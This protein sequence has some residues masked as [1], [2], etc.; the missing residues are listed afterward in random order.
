MAGEDLQFREN[1]VES[2]ASPDQVNQVAPITSPRLWI[3]VAAAATV[4]AAFVA[5]GVLGTIP[6][7]VRGTG[8]L[9]EGTMVVAAEAPLDGR[10]AEIRV[11][12]GDRVSQGDVLA[13]VANP[14]LEAQLQDARSAAVRLREQDAAM[15]AAEEQSLSAAIAALDAREQEARQRIEKAAAAADAFSKSVETKRDLVRQGLLA[16]AD[17]LGT[18]NTQLEIDR[19]LSECR[20]EL[21]RIAAD[22]ADA[23]IRHAQERQ[24][25][26][27]AIADADAAVRQAEARLDADR[28]VVAP[29]PGK[30]LQVLRGAGDVVRRGGS[31]AV[32][33][34]VGDGS[35][36]C[37]AFF[38]L[39]DGKRIAGA[40]PAR[41][42]P[43]VADRER[44]GVIAATVRDVEPMVGTRES[45]S[46]I[47]N[48]PEVAQDIERRY[49]G[50]VSAV[51]D[52][53]VDQSTP[54]GLR[55]SGGAGYPKPLVP[56]TICDVD[57][58]T[59]EVAPI[60]LLLPWIKQVVGG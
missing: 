40:M 10:I 47:I 45:L 3:L 26:R 34:D 55:W 59:E 37:Y 35:L 12:Q 52:L 29:R 15:G 49:G 20:N 28:N 48:S 7:T 27:N 21:R 58:V 22:R 9:I 30:A 5:W 24:R 43:S 32:I 41:V 17:L 4:T 57:V 11:R 2:A 23:G 53:A 6:L 14:A 54:T 60:R 50:I 13:I 38:P 39:A 56:G 25:R 19:A 18:V 33:S 51:L 8:L 16:E 46:R 42:E 44:F 36:R 1:A 31:V